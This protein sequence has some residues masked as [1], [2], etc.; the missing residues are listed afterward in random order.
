MTQPIR[1]VAV[2]AHVDHGKTTLVDCLLRQSGTF[3]PHEKLQERV[4]DSNDLERERG[5]TI[6]AKN[7]AIDYYETRINIVDTPGHADFGGEV[8]RVLGMVDGALLIVD[9]V[10]GPMPQTRFVLRKALAQNLKV[11]VVVNKIDRP[12]ARSTEVVDEVLDLFI[13][14]GASDEQCD[15]PLIYASAVQG[16]AT[17]DLEHPRADMQQLY[18]VIVEHV[19]PPVVH[20][21]EPLQLQVANI[22]YDEYVGHIGIGRLIQGQ[23]RLNDRI[24]VSTL[25]DGIRQV[26]VNKLYRFKGLKRYEITEAIPGDIIAFSGLGELH[27][28]ETLVDLNNPM[29]LPPIKVDEPTLQMTFAVN[30]SP[31]AGKEGEFVTSRHLRRRLYREMLSN[32]SLRVEDG[33]TTDLFYVSGRGELHLGILI[34]TMRREGFEFQISR[35][36]VIFKEID[37]QNC[38]PFETLVLDTPAEYVGSCIEALGRR[39]GEMVHMESGE[40]NRSVLTFSIPARGLIGYA[41]E[42]MRITK[43]E[44]IMSSTFEDYKPFK[45]EFEQTRNGAIW[46]M[47]AGTCSAYALQGLE[48][49][50]FF[51]IGPGTE[52]Y[53]GMIVGEHNRPQELP[54]N[55]TKTKKLT[56]MR[57]AGA[58]ELI[59]LK[60]PRHMSLEEAMSYIKD[61]ELIEITPKHMRFRKKNPKR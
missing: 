57:S 20:P 33:D 52:V 47:E 6:L 46:A 17:V 18:D 2:I 16:T 53:T 19:P 60:P 11:I 37:G 10:E 41:S 49:R 39:K 35:P 54:V 7:T 56:N 32:L 48:D 61:D 34:E 45:G 43:G 4:M 28:G 40:Q 14:L 9:S 12:F 55:V 24:G 21:E 42:Y 51:F 44:G 50:G 31:F 59:P 13:E 36:R 26:N 5:I 15:F 58:D 25:E 8:E 38:E 29:P 3:Q 27:I 23:L 30:D 22:D 1:N